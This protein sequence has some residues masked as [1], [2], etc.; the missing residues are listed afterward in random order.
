MGLTILSISSLLSLIAAPAIPTFSV[1][2][3]SDAR[4][5]D[6]STTGEWNN[7]CQP[8]YEC[9]DLEMWVI[10]LPPPLTNMDEAK[11]Q[12]SEFLR[13]LNGVI[14]CKKIPVA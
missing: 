9:I 8:F 13:P 12:G 11:C 14:L 2:Y 1:V 4:I 7:I 5:I 3:A 10:T 6:V